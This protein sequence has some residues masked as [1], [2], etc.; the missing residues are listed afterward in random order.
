MGL[1]KNI[2]FNNS[3]EPQKFI[4]ADKAFCS[5]DH[6]SGERVVIV[7]HFCFFFSYSHSYDLEGPFFVF[8]VRL[9]FSQ[10]GSR[11]K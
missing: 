2:L 9:S 6:K 8:Y 10:P 1:E 11:K 4:V 5:V 3:I 7:S